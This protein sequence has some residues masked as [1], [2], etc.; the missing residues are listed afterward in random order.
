MRLLPLLG[1]RGLGGLERPVGGFVGLYFGGHCRS[2]SV[3]GVRRSAWS[4]MKQSMLMR[5]SVTSER[6]QEWRQRG[7][8]MKR[9]EMSERL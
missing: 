3:K 9:S 8:G 7:Q 4:L 2:E 1:R 5:R 6:E